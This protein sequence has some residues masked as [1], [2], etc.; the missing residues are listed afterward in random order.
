MALFFK[1][2]QLMPMGTAVSLRY[3]SP[4]FAAGFAVLLLKEKMKNIQWVFFLTAFIGV[5]MLK[6][7]DHR[8]TPFGLAIII[9]CALLSGLVYVTVRRIG[10]SEHHIVIVNYFMTSAAIVGGL[11]SIFNWTQPVGYEW[12]IIICMGLIGFIAQ[13]FMTLALQL[14]EA[15][16]IAPFKYAEV[17]FTLIAGW[18]LFGEYQT[19]WTIGAMA[20]IILSLFAVVLIKQQ[21]Q[22][23]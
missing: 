21:N 19:I 14:A 3:L 23:T 8:V 13:I 2:I 15:N 7:F 20:I 10:K 17:I 1:A 5:V 9:A 12:L 4:F 6:G 16:L 11:L 18:L 22:T